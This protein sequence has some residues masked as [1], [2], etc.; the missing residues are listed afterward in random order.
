MIRKLKR[1]YANKPHWPKEFGADIAVGMLV[2]IAYPVILWGALKE[3]LQ[4]RY[5]HNGRHWDAVMRVDRALHPVEWKCRLCGSWK[6]FRHG[7]EMHS[8]PPWYSGQ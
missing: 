7:K 2:A 4:R 3:R 6:W 8:V 1:R 5:C